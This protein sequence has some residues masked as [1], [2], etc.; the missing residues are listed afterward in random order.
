MNLTLEE[1][2][3]WIIDNPRVTN[4]AEMLIKEVIEPLCKKTWDEGQPKIFSSV[5]NNDLFDQWKET[6]LK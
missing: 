5:P 2:I 1:R 3:Q 6:N 4:K